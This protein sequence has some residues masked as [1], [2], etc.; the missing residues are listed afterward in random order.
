[1]TNTKRALFLS[2]V[3]VILCIVMLASTTFAWFTD[4][5]ES[6]GN[7]IKTGEL[8]V[9]MSY[10]ADGQ[11]WENAENAKI[12]NYGLWEPGYTDVK[13]IKVANTGNLALEYQLNIIPTGDPSILADVID[14]YF[15]IVDTTYESFDQIKA[16]TANVANVGTLT[17]LIKDADG[18]AHGVLLPAEGVGS[19][20]VTLSVPE[21]YVQEG[22]FRAVVALHMQESAGND[23][24]NKSIGSSFTVQLLATQHTYEND[25]FDNMY[26]DGAEYD[27]SIP[28]WDGSANTDWYNETDT[29]FALTAAADLAGLAELVDG[30][31]MFEGKT[32]M[33]SSDINLYA[34]DADGETISFEPIGSYRNDTAFKGTF[35]GQGHTIYNMYQNGWALDNEYYLSDLGLGLFGLVEDAVV[36]NLN[37]DGANQ[38]SEFNLIGTVTGAA[39][40]EC[41][42]ENITV[43]NSYMGNH[44]YYSG[45]IVGWASGDH[46]YI[47]CDID[48]TSVISS[49][50]GDFNNANG[51]IIGGA[52]ANGTYYFEGCDVACVLDAYNDVTS[53]YEWYAYR[54]VGMLIGNT[55]HTTKTDGGTTIAA[56]PNVT[57]VDCTVTYGE[58]A[59]YTYCQF[60]AMNYP[61]VRVEAGESCHAYGNARYDYAVDANGNNVVDENHVH[62]EGEGHNVLIVLDQLF[63]GSQGGVYGN[64]EHEGVTVIY[65]NK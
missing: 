36:K 49:Q 57:C 26:D 21:A 50:W 8:K 27:K 28:E 56:A 44:S 41:T 33:L 58:W 31:N 38:P 39:Y 3:S 51:G 47:N 13:Y 1:M 62:N 17:S 19:S 5:V 2:I 37:I 25:S 6:T 20:D 10:S 35:D 32:I 23:Y 53:A 9:E 45:G 22:E 42:F 29:E 18:A 55:N 54:N 59:N 15:G 43:T 48:A 40:G 46:K 14:V 64:P 52:G 16:D 63:G 11:K 12:F 60:K 30:G 24:Q 34:A 65:N 61:W 4:S 7:I